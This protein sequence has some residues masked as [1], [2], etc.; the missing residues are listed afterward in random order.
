MLFAGVVIIGT[1]A[2]KSIAADQLLDIPWGVVTVFGISCGL[3][4]AQ[5]K[6]E[7]DAPPSDPPR[8]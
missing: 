4:W 5:M 8:L 7:S 2:G 6:H 1:W 3:K